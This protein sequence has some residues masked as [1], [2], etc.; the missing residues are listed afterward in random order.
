MG[1][2]RAVHLFAGTALVAQRAVLRDAM[3]GIVGKLFLELICVGESKVRR[4]MRI[5]ATDTRG[6]SRS[7]QSTAA[8]SQVL[9]ASLP[10]RT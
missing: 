10:K 6:D 7:G 4:G 1:Y 8:F 9:K 5:V 2:R 3:P